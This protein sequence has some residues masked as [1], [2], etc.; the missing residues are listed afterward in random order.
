MARENVVIGFDTDELDLLIEAL[1]ALEYW[2]FGDVLPR[3][4]GMVFI[5]GDMPFGNDRYWDPDR[6]VSSD[7]AEA[8]EQVRR[9]RRLA[10][11]LRKA[12]QS[13]GVE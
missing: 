13:E 9:C 2:Q 5:P 3:N 4:D 11:R 7:E 1:D 12:L 6:S 8:I 10:D